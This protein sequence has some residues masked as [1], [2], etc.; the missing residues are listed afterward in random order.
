MLHVVYLPEPKRFPEE[1]AFVLSVN[2]VTK[3]SSRFVAP[4][5]VLVCLEQVIK[6][7][8]LDLDDNSRISIQA[9][10]FGQVL[11]LLTSPTSDS[12]RDAVGGGRDP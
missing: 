9:G 11:L 8:L 3:A 12:K 4:E 2:R 1:L 5:M 10:L 7:P 6:C